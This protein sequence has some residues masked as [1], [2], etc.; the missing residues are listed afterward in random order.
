[1]SQTRRTISAG[2]GLAGLAALTPEKGRAMSKA[3][4]TPDGLAA[5]RRM[6]EGHVAKGSAPGVVAL[7]DRGGETHAF[8]A[9]TRAL[10][11]GGPMQRDTIFR[12]A[13]MTKLV[14]A[15]AVM[16][17][18]DE[19]KVRLD[20]PV[21]R[22]LPELADRRVLKRPDGPLDDTVPAKRPITVEDLLTF[23]LGL[24]AFSYGP[25]VRFRPTRA[26]CSAQAAL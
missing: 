3:N 16:M 26:P 23:R 4:F 18:A 20:E 13:S 22:L 15:T 14:T 8:T 12:I 7:L 25:Q 9:G 2:L 17:L 10:G 1:M 5:M 19:G 11:G 6:L 21:D 24:A